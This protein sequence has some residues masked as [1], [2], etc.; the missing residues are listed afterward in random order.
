VLLSGTDDAKTATD[1]SAAAP[2]PVSDAGGTLS[3]DDGAGSITVDGTV[4]ISGTVPVSDGGGSLTV[5]G[6]VAISGT[7]PV[8]D[9]GGTL[10]IDD[11]GG[12]LTVDG[13]VAI[14]G[15]V[16]V[17]DAGGSLTVDGSV[18]LAAALPA[19]SNNIGDVDVLT[20]PARVRTTDAISV[21]HQTDAMMAGLN[22]LTPK[23]ASIAASSTGDN[24]IVAL[25]ASKKIRV[26]RFMLVAAGAVSVKFKTGSGTDLT[27]AM[28]IAANG[29]VGAPYCPIGILESASGEALVLNLSAAVA[30]AG[31]LTYIEV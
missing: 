19:G 8:S 29:G 25:V 30:V 17:S 5:D 15:T 20:Q 11:G 1:V 7:V 24:T 4:A 27:G 28:A 10:T 6:T 26:L 22:A 13:T 14:S 12:S 3:I 21:A 31:N 18:S 16:P 23:F 2:L 9:A